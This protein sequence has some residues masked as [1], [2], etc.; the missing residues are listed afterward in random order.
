VL[1]W[2]FPAERGFVRAVRWILVSLLF[3]SL[4]PGGAGARVAGIDPELQCMPWDVPQNAPGGEGLSDWEFWERPV[5]TL[6]GAVIFVDFPD[7]PATETTQAAFDQVAAPAAPF[8]ESA[9][10]GALDLRL[11]P[12]HEWLRMSQSSSTYD[13]SRDDDRNF[14][15]YIAYVREAVALADPE[16]DFS[17]TDLVYVVASADAD[18]NYSPQLSVFPGHGATADENEILQMATI[19]VDTRIP[20]FGEYVLAHETGHMFSLPDLYP[21]DGDPHEFVGPW[22]LMGDLTLG[23]GFMAWHK[24]KL[25]WLGIEDVE[26]VAPGSEVDVVISP[27]GTPGGTKAAVVRTGPHTAYVAELRRPVGEDSRLCDFGV[28]VY[29]V[30]S[31]IPTGEGPIRVRSARGTPERSAAYCGLGDDAAFDRGEGEDAVFEDP[32]HGVRIEVLSA[33]ATSYTVRVTNGGE[34]DATSPVVYA[35]SVTAG[36]IDGSQLAGNV[37]AEDDALGC[38]RQVAVKVQKKTPR[39]FRTVQTVFTDDQGRFEATL[40]NAQGKRFR[41]LAAPFQ[42]STFNTCGKAVSAVVR[43]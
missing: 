11:E 43:G 20:N 32:E 15:E 16:F 25:G 36:L 13:L 9:S 31:S 8:Y 28:L 34:F 5:G 12:H 3:V 41:A 21:Y 35:R 26:C 2:G 24:M 38:L 42:Y 10:Y 17:A 23:A 18:A 39:G 4:A 22:D 37:D 6:R 30:D 19:G 14:L 29:E 40:S 1:L 33:G 27:L 7:A